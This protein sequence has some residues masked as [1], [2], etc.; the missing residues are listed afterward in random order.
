ME[1]KEITNKEIWE[2]FLM[3]CKEKTFLDSWN[4]GEFQENEEGKMWRLGICDGNDI[5]AVSL[6]ILIKAK[7]GTFLFSPHGPVY[8]SEKTN[9]KREIVKILLEKLKEIGER[10]K[11][12]FIR[13]SPIWQRNTENEDIFKKLGFKEAPIHMHP[14]VT[15]E[16]DVS[17]DKEKLLKGMRKTT[18]YLIRQAEKNSDIEII[19]TGEKENL[20]DFKKIYDETVKR[21]NFTPFSLK[22]LENQFDSFVRDSQIVIFLG[23]YKKETVSSAI[24]VFW[25]NLAFYHHGAS[26][27]KFNKIPVSYLL[28][29]EA[30]KEAKNRGCVLYNFWGIAPE[31]TSESDASKSRHPW[32]GLSLFK[33][34]FGGYRKDY[35]KTQDYPLTLKYYLNFIIERIRKIKR[36]L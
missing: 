1:I 7:R 29:W 4:W 17:K 11:A 27:S 18:R 9:L 36:R 31:V 30:I 5:I 3:K 24:I 28:Q 12:D 32:A 21:H 6:V 15:W 19:K 34:G 8:W 22:Y 2:N 25:Q 23:K 26:L 16:L 35:V 20:K 14:E 33:M 13:I 10:E